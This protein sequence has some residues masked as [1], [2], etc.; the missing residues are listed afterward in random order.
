MTGW[1]TVKEKKK[2][3][4]RSHFPLHWVAV[5]L[6]THLTPLPANYLTKQRSSTH[7]PGALLA[8][9]LQKANI[10]NQLLS[11]R[12]WK[13]RSP[14]SRSTR[15]VKWHCQRETSNSRASLR[16]RRHKKQMVEAVCVCVCV[17]V[18]VCISVRE[19]AGCRVSSRQPLKA[20]RKTKV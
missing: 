11:E 13:L 6:C 10:V 20:I 4:S 12:S 5:Q 1:K 2:S 15:P 9:G 3:F 17:G 14:L 8:L 7:N 18:R 16:G 19:T